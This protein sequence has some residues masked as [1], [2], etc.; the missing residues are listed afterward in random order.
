[1]CQP[2]PRACRWSDFNWSRTWHVTAEPWIIQKIS[3]TVVDV[4]DDTYVHFAVHRI[5][6]SVSSVTSSIVKVYEN[7]KGLLNKILICP[8]GVKTSSKQSWTTLTLVSLKRLTPT[9][10]KLRIK[11]SKHSSTSALIHREMFHLV[12]K[13]KKEK[14]NR[15]RIAT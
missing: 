1:M 13:K 8:H 9:L 5:E 4:D 2:E 14:K 15:L 11:T 12:Q 6:T 10:I 7:H 3:V